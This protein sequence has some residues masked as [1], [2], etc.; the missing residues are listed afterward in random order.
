MTFLKV[1]NRAEESLHIVT[2]DNRPSTKYKEDES[3]I[4]NQSNLM[5]P[6]LESMVTLFAELFPK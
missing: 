4:V 3:Q 1:L 5:E 2:N 6:Y